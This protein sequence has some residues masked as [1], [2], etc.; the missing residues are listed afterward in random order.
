MSKRSEPTT[1]PSASRSATRSSAPTTGFRMQFAGQ[2]LLAAAS[3]SR[4]VGELEAQHKGE[5]FGPFFDEILWNATA[6]VILSAASL[7]AYVN[8]IA[9][10]RGR[11][12]K[13]HAPELVDALWEK[14]ER[15]QLLDK[16]DLALL[17]LG[18]T[19]LDRGAKLCQNVHAL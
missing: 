17:L 3:F 11:H 4:R 5:T 10:D 8:E 15:D 2:H 18:K 19:P 1:A 7:E 6:S 13:G 16:Y 12:F 9:A 14:S